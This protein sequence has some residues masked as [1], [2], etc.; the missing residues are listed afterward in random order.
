MN[1]MLSWLLAGHMM[2]DYL[3]QN[4]WMATRKTRSLRELV[5]HASIYTAAIWVASLP[6]GGLGLA[7]VVLVFAAH[8]VIDKRDVTLWWC[9]H[10]THSADTEWLVLVT[11][12][13]LHVIIL[14]LVCLIR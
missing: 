11:D 8:A 13:A 12:Q 14:A 7:G 1:D 5:V 3:L 6:A 10:V 9:K 2:G 4:R